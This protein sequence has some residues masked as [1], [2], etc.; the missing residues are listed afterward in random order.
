MIYALVLLIS[1]VTSPAKAQDH[2]RWVPP[3][4]WGDAE[5]HM[6]WREEH[7]REARRRHMEWCEQHPYVCR[8]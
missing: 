6:Q 3:G 4:V 8:R 7:R 1:L 5:R 2:D